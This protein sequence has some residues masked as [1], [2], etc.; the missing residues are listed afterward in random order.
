MAFIKID[1]EFLQ[2][3][4]WLREPFTYGQAWVDLI[5]MA[6]WADKDKFFRHQH[7]RVKRGQIVTSQQAL[8]ERWKWSRNKV[9]TYLRNIE[10]AGMVQIDSTT[11]YTTITIEKYGTYQDRP[12]TK[13]Q[14]KA[15]LT[16]SAR[17]TDG[18]LTA[19]QEEYRKKE[20]PN[21][22]IYPSRADLRS[23]VEEEGLSADPDE[24]FDYYEAVG[25]E[26]NGK[27]IKDWRAV[28][29]R[30]KSYE[31]PKAEQSQEDQDAELHRLLD[32]MEKGGNIYD[33][34]GS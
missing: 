29:R 25:W 18:Q 24:I 3:D 16:A 1:R 28:C 31:K 9:R 26:I 11:N 14:E 6:N 21:G 32:I 2:S 5:G 4:F 12:P 8:A 20:Y 15:Q 7:Q 10:R 33:T 30:W 23:Y 19:T 27:P 34:T 17:P 13:R 22:Y